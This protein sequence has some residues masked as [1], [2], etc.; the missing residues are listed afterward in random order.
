[1]RGGGVILQGNGEYLDG[2]KGIHTVQK[3]Q[4]LTS[5]VQS[6]RGRRTGEAMCICSCVFLYMCKE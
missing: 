6:R 1:M 2:Q 4:C 3:S 5:K